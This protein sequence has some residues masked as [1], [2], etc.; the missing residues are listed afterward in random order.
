MKAVKTLG[1]LC[2]SFI[3]NLTYGQ[4][5]TTGGPSSTLDSNVESVYLA[6]ENGSSISYLGCPGLTGLED[7]TILSVDLAANS[8]YNLFVQFGTCGGNYSGVGSAY[9][10]F[11]QDQQFDVSEQVGSWSGTPPTAMSQFNFTVPSSTPIG[12]ARMRIIQAENATIPIDPCLA[13]TWGSMVDFTVNFTQG[14]DCSGYI[15]DDMS[16]PRTINSLPYSESYSSALCYSNTDPVYN[17]PDVYYMMDVSNLNAEFINV[18]LC[19]STFDTYLSIQDKDTNVLYTNDDYEFC[20][21]QSELTFPTAG[22]DTVYVIVQGWGNASGDYDININDLSVAEIKAIESDKLTLFPNPAKD[23]IT[24]QTPSTENQLIQIF[25]INGA[26]VFETSFVHQL[27]LE[28]TFLKP[29]MY[30][31]KTT[32]SNGTQE[33][34]LIIEP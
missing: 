1:I 30:L 14:I 18:S 16:D 33:N 6:G 20:G 19:G 29:G 15:G 8:N 7:Q 21:P 32:S 11:N 34:K 24:I 4:Y 26:L 9:I 2:I 12:T 31:V 5:C 28:T 27:K 25:N 10:D 13:F 3:T 17:S 23:L 22:L